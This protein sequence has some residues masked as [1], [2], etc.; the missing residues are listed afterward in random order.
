MISGYGTGGVLELPDPMRLVV[1]QIK[2]R[3]FTAPE[4]DARRSQFDQDMLEWVLAGRMHSPETILDGIEAVPEGLR[5]VLRGGNS[6]KLLVR[7]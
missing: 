2:M 5:S 7:L 1:R 6:G 4:F 3:G